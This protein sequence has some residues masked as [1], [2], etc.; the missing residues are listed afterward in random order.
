MIGCSVKGYIRACAP[1]TGGVGLLLVGDANDWEF[2]EGAPDTNGDA[3]GYSTVARRT[4]A[5]ALGGAYLYPIDSLEDSISVDITQ[6]NTEGSSSAYEYVIAAR[7]AQM[8]QAM[9]NFNKKI[10][11]AALC[12]QLVFVYQTNDGKIMVAGEKYVGGVRQVPFKIRQDGSKFTTGKKFTDFNGQDLSL[13]GTYNRLPYEFTGGMGVI[14]G[15]MP[16]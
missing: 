8:S 15:F 5:T 7:L 14:Q 2:T 16:S 13:K 12:C 6:S 4:G 1:A 3:T 11:A 9:T 10:D